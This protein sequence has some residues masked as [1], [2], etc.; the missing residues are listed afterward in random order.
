M[1]RPIK[2][3]KVDFIPEIT[4][5]APCPKSSCKNLKETKKKE[6][7]IKIEEVEALRLK[8]IE[9]L[10]QEECARK[11]E[12]SRQTF[13]NILEEARRKVATALVEGNAIS[14]GGGRYTRNVCHLRCL[15][16]GKVQKISMEDN[17]KKCQ[18]CRSSNIICFKRAKCSYVCENRENN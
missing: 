11:M 5:Y 16:C 2:W 15:S 18:H 8:D 13:Q 3:R 1:P 6:M 4:Y 9:G 17:T 7:Q 14:I 10:S 12:V